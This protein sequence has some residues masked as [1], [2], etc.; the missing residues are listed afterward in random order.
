MNKT[1]LLAHNTTHKAVVIR[2]PDRARVY[3]YDTSPADILRYALPEATKEIIR[4]LC[5]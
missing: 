3:K 2:E 1:V 5:S 4:S